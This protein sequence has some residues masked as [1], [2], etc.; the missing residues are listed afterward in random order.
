M[1]RAPLRGGD[2]APLISELL[3]TWSSSAPGVL[4]AVEHQ[5][6]PDDRGHYH[7][8]IRLRGEEKDV[9]TVWLSLRQRT[10]HVEVE[11]V[12]APEENLD[13]VYRFALVKNAQMRELH[14]ALGPENG[15]Y[16]MTQVPIA[17]M[18]LDRLDEVIGAS[19]T[20]VDELFPTMMTLGHRAYYRRRQRRP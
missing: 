18:T 16:L 6:L 9:I 2:D 14:L 8:L 19:V 20:Y 15:I 17:E 5:P 10:V 7:W 4:I 1:T 12:P 11:V 3:A 13:E